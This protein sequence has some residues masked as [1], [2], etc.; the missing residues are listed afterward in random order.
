MKQLHISVCFFL[1]FVFYFILLSCNNAKEA[2]AT[3]AILDKLRPLDDFEISQDTSEYVDPYSENPVLGANESAEKLNLVKKFDNL[4]V[5]HANDTMNL[6][7][8]YRATL[9]VARNAALDPL[10]QS[11][12]RESEA[13]DNKVIID[14]ITKLGKRIRANLRDVGP[15]RDKSF[16]IEPFGTDEQ[17]LDKTKERYWQ[18]NIEPL[19]E[20]PHKLRLSVEV[21][22][23]D[24]NELNLPA[25]NIPVIIF[26][27]K[28][29]FAT[30]V[31]N[32]FSNYWQWIITGIFLPIFIA[33]LTT[34]IKQPNVAKK[35]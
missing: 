17:N 18:W 24:G 4:L 16:I 6:N 20:G 33:W 12:L 31:G 13:T 1:L 23:G 5:F 11:V 7:E 14:S 29:S 2:D 10:I 35:K 28:V 34:R 32:F 25:R 26:G 21:I 3:R 30:K 27:K 8:T 9:A 15:T 22:L 19:K